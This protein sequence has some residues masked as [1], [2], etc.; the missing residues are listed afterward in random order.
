MINKD[1]KCI[2]QYTVSYL[3]FLFFKKYDNEGL[4][5]GVCGKGRGSFDS[6]G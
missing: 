6:A 1:S 3:P 2:S 4:I 5:V